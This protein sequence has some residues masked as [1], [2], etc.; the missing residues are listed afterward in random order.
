VLDGG[1]PGD[2]H[3]FLRKL[4]LDG[5]DPPRLANLQVG[6]ASG[7]AEQAV[8]TGELAKRSVQPTPPFVF[9]LFHPSS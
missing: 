2:R 1:D 4:C 6:R 7:P 8:I 9:L 3:D 5:G